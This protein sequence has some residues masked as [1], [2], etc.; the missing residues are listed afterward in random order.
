MSRYFS[1]VLGTLLLVV[2]L[3]GCG[4]QVP[5][6]S[7]VTTPAPE[8]TPSESTP[9]P[10]SLSLG[11]GNLPSGPAS[12]PA[13]L[14]LGDLTDRINAQWSGLTRFRETNSSTAGAAAVP[15]SPVAASP[16]VQRMSRSV[17]EVTLPDRA[18]Y[19]AEENGQLVYEIIVVGDQVF[20]RGT[21]ATLLDPTT[22]TGEWV[23]TDLQTV[24]GNPMLGDAAARQLATLAAPAYVIPDRLRPQTVRHL[25]ATLLEGRRCLLYGA[26]DTTVTGAR[27]DLTFAVDE[28][29]RLCFVETKSI[30]IASRYVVEELEETFAIP[31]PARARPL[32]TPAATPDSAATSDAS[33]SP[34][35][36]P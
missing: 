33:A 12:P 36:R 18:R 8:P 25:G 31:A 32:A 23:V 14:N 11:A 30:E 34:K 13:D 1:V 22:A 19:F 35:A 5:S 3:A 4:N 9:A 15:G 28:T 16:P 17:R 6:T 26:A 24:G 21:V 29:D 7:Q 2:F 20:A 27:I 10:P